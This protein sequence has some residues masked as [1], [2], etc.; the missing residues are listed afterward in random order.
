LFIREQKGYTYGIRSSFDGNHTAGP[1]VVSA[2]VRANVTDSS[3]MDVMDILK[4]YSDKGITKKELAFTQ[5]SLEAREALRYETNI[6]KERFIERMIEYNLSDN[7]VNDQ[8][9]ALKK[10]KAKEVNKL[11]QKYLPLDHMVIVV[12]GD[13]SKLKDKLSKLGYDVVDYVDTTAPVMHQGD[14]PGSIKN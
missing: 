3:I 5:S 10:L 2:G 12:V 9:N 6:Q 7:Y 14:V 8:L 1:F 11:A 13:A 4:K